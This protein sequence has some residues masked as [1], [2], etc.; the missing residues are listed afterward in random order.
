MT[1]AEIEPLL[2]AFFD[3]ELR[4]EDMRSV[5]RHLAACPE[6]EKA[7]VRMEHL[8][9][10]LRHAVL[11]EVRGAD[12][13]A[14][15]SDLSS[16][17]E[18]QRRGLLERLRAVLPDGGFVVPRSPLVWAGTAATLALAVGLALGLSRWGARDGGKPTRGAQIAQFSG[19]ESLE[20]GGVRVWNKPESDTLVIWVDD[21]GLG[22][23]RLD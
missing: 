6:C 20:S 4:G 22:M 2:D 18:P 21:Q 12:A 1:C 10:A 7:S 14:F 9:G 3:G 23:E 16:R 17:L 15:W 11:A 19:I 8:Q 5:A 13:S